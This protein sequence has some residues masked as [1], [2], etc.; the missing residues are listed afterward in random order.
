VAEDPAAVEK[1]AAGLAAGP[2]RDSVTA[3]L[4]ANPLFSAGV[5]LKTYGWDAQ[6]WPEPAMH[7]ARWDDGRAKAVAAWRDGI[8]QLTGKPADGRAAEAL[9]ERLLALSDGFR[10]PPIQNL[11]EPLDVRIAEHLPAADRE[12]VNLRLARSRDP[13][14]VHRSIGRLAAVESAAALDVLFAHADGRDREL[15]EAALSWLGNYKSNPRIVQFLRRK[16]TDPDPVLALEAAIITCYS[17][18]WSGLP[19]ILRCGRSKDAD[20]RLRAIGQLGSDPFRP[21]AAKVVPILLDE[22]KTP[23]SDAHLERAIESLQAYPTGPVAEAVTP[24]LK[25][26]NPQVRTRARLVLAQIER[27]REKQ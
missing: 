4:K 25:H 13:W 20:L 18:D 17:G 6:A 1:L 21:H 23:L 22:L 11:F 15:A 19:A 14:V 26:G 7:R 9:V 10:V 12:R 27:D 24:F 8:G 5:Q 16:M 3:L 2:G